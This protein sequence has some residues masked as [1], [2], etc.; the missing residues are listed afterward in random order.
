MRFWKR[1]K[2][3]SRWDQAQICSSIRLEMRAKTVQSLCKRKSQD[4]NKLFWQLAKLK[5]KFTIGPNYPHSRSHSGKNK[6]ILLDKIFPLN[7]EVFWLPL[8]MGGC[9]KNGFW[10]VNFI[11]LQFLRCC[12]YHFGN[13]LAS[14]P[15]ILFKFEIASSHL[16]LFRKDSKNKALYTA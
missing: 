11:L 10:P 6:K 4:S 1:K 2:R 8:K 15:P 16:F 14:T 3:S 12:F 13:I 5:K 7:F 9:C